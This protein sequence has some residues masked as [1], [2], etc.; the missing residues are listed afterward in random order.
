MQEATGDDAAEVAAVGREYAEMRGE[1]PAVVR[2]VRRAAESA[3]DEGT[4]EVLDAFVAGFLAGRR[5]YPPRPQSTV[6]TE[7][8]E[9]VR[10][11]Y[12]ASLDEVRAVLTELRDKVDAELER[13]PSR[14]PKK[15]GAN[16]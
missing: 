12:G 6:V 2:A 8:I 1:G 16:T 11:L 10:G 9:R 4:A 13:L 3:V 5:G 14:A 15:G 7:T